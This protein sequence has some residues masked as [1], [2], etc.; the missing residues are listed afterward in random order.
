ML[1]LPDL[2][3]AKTALDPHV[4][5]RTLDFHHGKHHATYVNNANNMIKDSP[6]ADAS[7]EEIIAAAA[8][9]AVR[10]EVNWA[11]GELEPGGLVE[12]I[13]PLMLPGGGWE[14]FPELHPFQRL[15]YPRRPDAT[16]F[17]RLAADLASIP[18]R[19]K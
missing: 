4:S 13:V 7:L 18:C 17:D 16:F 12:R 19:R 5:E 14:D 3:Y 1:E 11:L 8:S 6:L 9:D 15:D 10:Q 2:P